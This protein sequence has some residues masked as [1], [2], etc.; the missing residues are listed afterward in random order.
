MYPGNEYGAAAAV[1][2]QAPPGQVPSWDPTMQAGRSTYVSAP[3]TFPAQNFATSSVPAYAAAATMPA[4]SSPLAQTG[5]IA[6]AAGSTVL[7]QPGAPPHVRP[8]GASPPGVRPGG[9]SP[10][11]QPPYYGQ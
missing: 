11:G 9:V 1:Q 8:G 4:G 2:G 6:S 10:P 5:T 3:G 7:S